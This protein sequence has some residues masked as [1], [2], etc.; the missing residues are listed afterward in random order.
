V[1]EQLSLPD[2]STVLPTLHMRDHPR[3]SVIASIRSAGG[4][5]TQRGH[6]LRLMH[7]AGWHGLT[8]LEATTIMRQRF[9]KMRSV[10]PRIIELRDTGW[11]L[12]DETRTRLTDTGSPAHVNIF[13]P[14]AE[15]E[16]ARWVERET[17]KARGS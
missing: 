15:M 7:D 11:L 13:N 3:T 8:A 10:Y 16:Y 1:N 17:A 2:P 4:A 5:A 9:P 14:D 6:L 12:T